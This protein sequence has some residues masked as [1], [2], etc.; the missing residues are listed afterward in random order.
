VGALVI[1][2]RFGR[3]WDCSEDEGDDDAVAVVGVVAEGGV[4]DGGME[5]TRAS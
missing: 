1:V 3:L 5:L 2:S 4:Y